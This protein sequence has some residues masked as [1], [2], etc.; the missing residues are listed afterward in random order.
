[1]TLYGKGFYTWKL[2]RCEGGDAAA[3]AATA[4][5]ANLTYVLIKVADGTSV[6]NGLWGNPHDWV[7]PTIQELRSQGIQ[8]WG[9]QYVYGTNPSSEANIAIQRIQQFQLDGFVVDAEKEFK[10]P[11]KGEIARKYMSQL[12][13]AVPNIPIALSSYRYPSLH[14]QFPWE[15][16]LEKCDIN[17]PQVYWVGAH[18]PGE[19]LQRCVSEFQSITPNRPIIPTGLA[20]VERSFK[21]TPAETHEFMRTA[22]SLNLTG[23]NF[24]MWDD[25]RSDKLPGIWDTIATY[26]YSTGSSMQDICQAFIAALNSHNP[27]QVVEIY[28]STAAHTTPDR[29]IQGTQEIHAWYKTFLNELLPNGNFTLTSFS[30]SGPSRHFTWTATSS[31][32]YVNNGN[33]TFGV[34]DGKIGYHL[35][36]FTITK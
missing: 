27:E 18:N 25:A 22:Q 3:I 28:T 8:I 13:A 31:A 21:P 32:G 29:T 12:R 2:S 11:G 34:I 24:W 33:D 36:N 14:A 26:D 30:G 6:Y 20:S 7:T 10:H 23:V 17:M 9:W 35:Q 15:I 4:K 5:M 16:F 1:M 19:Q